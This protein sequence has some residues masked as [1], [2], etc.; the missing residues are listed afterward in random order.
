M[1][2]ED[3]KHAFDRSKFQVLCYG[4]NEDLKNGTLY[5]TDSTEHIIDRFS[6]LKSP[7]SDNI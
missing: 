2:R 3:K 6:S 1:A 7:R 5:F 4:P